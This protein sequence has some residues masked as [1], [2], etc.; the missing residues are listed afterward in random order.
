[1]TVF[2]RVLHLVLLLLGGLGVVLSVA[3]IVGVWIADAR[4]R[5][6]A[7]DTR[8]QLDDML[9]AVDRRVGQVEQRVDESALTTNEVKQTLEVAAKREVGEQLRAR[10]EIDEKAGR[11]ATLLHRADDWL[12]TSTT[13]VKLVERTLRL[14]NTSGAAI[15]TTSLQRLLEELASLDAKLNEATS[16]V[17]GIRDHT[18]DDEQGGPITQRLQ[19]AARLALRVVAALGVVQERLQSLR[20]KLQSA[21]ADLKTAESKLLGRIRTGAVA[22]TLLLVW[23]LLG[24]LALGRYGW[25]GL[26]Q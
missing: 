23:V 22:L 24:Q 5:R 2:K 9:T 15:D 26:R 8:D 20:V 19:Q 21:Q 14:V 12:D 25:L 4:L 16:L 11:L 6:A 13:S 7:S 3:L 17:E 1:M 18:R 10:L